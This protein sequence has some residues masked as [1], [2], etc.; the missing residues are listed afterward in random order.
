MK[1]IHSG[2]AFPAGTSRGY[3]RLM[4]GGRR[5]PIHQLG[6]QPSVRQRPMVAIGPAG[7]HQAS[8]YALKTQAD[9]RN[10]YSTPAPQESFLYANGKITKAGS[11][12][13]ARRCQAL[14]K[15][16]RHQ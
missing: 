11:R 8:A 15:S 9:R 5:R 2:I 1:D 3:Q 13:R 16:L 6:F 10:Y 7:A 4:N 14:R 12:R